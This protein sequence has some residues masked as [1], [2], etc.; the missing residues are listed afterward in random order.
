VGLPADP[1]ARAGLFVYAKDPERLAAFYAAIAGLTRLQDVAGIIVLESPDIQLLVHAIP[2]HIA[3]DI[4]ITCPPQ[5]REDAALKFFLTVPSLDAARATALEFGGEVFSENWRGTG[6]IACN[7]MD[8]EG[9]IF[10][11]REPAD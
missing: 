2:A 4:T 7:A 9:N 6:F 1:P 10:Q 8:P 5:P 11:L 3:G